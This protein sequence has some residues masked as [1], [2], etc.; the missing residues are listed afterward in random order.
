M[1]K[2]KVKEK[3]IK[4]IG[5][6]DYNEYGKDIV[7]SSV[8][9]II[10]TSINAILLFNSDSIKYTVKEGMVNIRILKQEEATK[11]LLDNM[12]KMLSEL[13]SQYPENIKIERE[14]NWW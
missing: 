9:S 2:V 11:K 8:S 1:I 3:C 14:W 12:L 10:T 4:I 13:E 5:H 7:C 6:A